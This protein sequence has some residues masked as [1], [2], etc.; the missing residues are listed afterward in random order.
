MCIDMSE[1]K[2]YKEKALRDSEVKKE[3]DALD[4]EYEKIQAEIQK[5]SGSASTSINNKKKQA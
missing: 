3:Y 4:T 5:A 1:Y 2:E